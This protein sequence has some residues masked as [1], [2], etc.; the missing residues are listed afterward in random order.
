MSA[1][2]T[3]F[4][5]GEL[6]EVRP[7]DEILATLDSRGELDALP[8][9][10]EMLQFCGRRMKVYRRA[11]KTCDTV[12]QRGMHLIDAVHLEGARC[13]G[14]AHGGCEARCL[15]FWKEQ[16]LKR[17]EDPGET[18]RN[19]SAGCDEAMLLGATEQP[20]DSLRF[21]CQATEMP[22]AAATH[23][24]WWDVRQYIRDV[25]A[26]NATAGEMAKS[27][28]VMLF[29]KFQSFDRKFLPG[30]GLI[31]G[32][33]H[34]PFLDGAHGK[35]PKRAIGLEPGDRVR[36]RSRDQVIATLDPERK[37]RGLS[38]DAE[39]A[40]YCGRE[41]RVLARVNQIIEEHTGRMIS[42]RD[43]VILEGVICTGKHY[44]YCPRSIFPYWREVWLDLV[45]RATE[46]PSEQPLVQ[47]AAAEGSHASGET[48]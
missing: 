45:E 2:A 12:R 23:L 44:Q 36:V 34:W 47:V 32:A 21:R 35:T 48:C 6:V 11:V 25:R 31:R 5:P 3:S 13:S 10:P 28:L 42:L 26:G 17:A 8:F 41:Y 30:K 40:E 14:E 16:W 29:N 38:F 22:R 46:A 9:M 15:L 37:N 39:M 43:C 27:L 19:G 1:K 20:G 33:Q 24:P 7:K 18:S 4:Q